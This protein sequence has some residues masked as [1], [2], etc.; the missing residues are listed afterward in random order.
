MQEHTWGR[1]ASCF[2]SI[3][4]TPSRKEMTWRL[5]LYFSELPAKELT[6]AVYLSIARVSSESNGL[7]MNVGENSLLKALSRFSTTSTEALRKKMQ[8]SGDISTVVSAGKRPRLF[9]AKRKTLTLEAVFETLERISKMAGKDSTLKK[10][11]I[12]AELLAQCTEN[13][14]V[15]YVVRALDGKMKIGLSTQTVLCSLALAFLAK[16]T[17]NGKNALAS[18]KARSEKAAAEESGKLLKSGDS[19]PAD[20]SSIEWSL[21]EIAAMEEMKEAYAQLPS[22]EK[23]IRL[24]DEKGLSSLKESLITPGYPL[25]PMLAIAEKD[26]ETAAS[27]FSGK[28]LVEYKYDGERVQA[29]FFGGKVELFS[30]GLEN[31]TERFRSL[32]EPLVRANITQADFIL[33]AEVVAYCRKA[34][35]ILSFQTL[36]N[37]KRKLTESNADK[38]ESEIALFVFDLIYLGGPL[39][40]LPLPERKQMLAKSFRETAGEIEVARSYAFE[41]HSPERLSEIFAESIAAGCEGVM[42]KSADPES[43]YEPSKRSQK[44]V[45]LKSDYVAGLHETMD[46]L[47]IGGYLGKGKRTGVYGGFLLGCVNALGD[48]EALTKIGTGF[49]ESVL[50]E[51]ARALQ[52]HVTETAQASTGAGNAPDVWF[53]PVLVWEVAAAGFS[54]SPLYTAG[55]GAPELPE[56][57]GISLRFPR[58]VRARA[59]KTLETST[60]CE[61]ILHMF[62]Q[63]QG[64]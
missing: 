43:T 23:I 17:P 24:V 33:D 35:K 44:W 60:T 6:Q 54:I 48:V 20:T 31:T 56:G 5:A 40:K 41:E 7:E 52:P 16:H 38:E 62:K 10:I 18:R 4:D 9:F 14:E 29:H 26:P 39:S 22:F 55:L 42:I 63:T 28:Y 50:E 11:E 61:Q 37:R 32:V 8:A 45:K 25:R 58:F 46:L 34:G 27:R 21:E 51:I 57:R 49:S 59:D 12:I 15:K 47:V 3:E 64:S 36:S 1:A 2:Q 19:E 13:A 30:R 53:K